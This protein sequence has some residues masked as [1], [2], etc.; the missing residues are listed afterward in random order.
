MNLF[1]RIRQ[2]FRP[3]P[4]RIGRIRIAWS[5]VRQ[6][7]GDP[8]LSPMMGALMGELTVLSREE[9]DGWLVITA[10][11]DQFD[12]IQSGEAIPFY[13]FSYQM[14]ASAGGSRSRCTF[15]RVF[16][17]ALPG[18][19]G[20]APQPAEPAPAALTPF[21]AVAEPPAVPVPA[22]EPAA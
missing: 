10:L 7:E 14:D 9:T 19:A 13:R 1:Q 11:C 20:P 4:R 17:S 5:L 8:I 6:S 18:A 22:P 3:Q 2:F 21:A 16:A 15:E 12:P